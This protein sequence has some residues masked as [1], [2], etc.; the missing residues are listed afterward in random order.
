MTVRSA[1]IVGACSGIAIAI[2][3]ELA[4]R[5]FELSLLARDP[6][7]LDAVA[8][9]LRARGAT[10]ID[11]AALDLCDTDAVERVFDRLAGTGLRPHLVLLAQGIMRENDECS[12][13]PAVLRRMFDTNLA[14][15]AH[16]ALRAVALMGPSADREL[17]VISSVAGDRGRP[18]NYC[19]GATKAGLDAFLEG[20]R[21]AQGRDGPNVMNLKPGPVATAMSAHLEKGPLWAA[22]DVVARVVCNAMGKRR[23]RVYAPRWWRPVMWV[24]RQLPGSVLARLGI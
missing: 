21:L 19:Y 8:E 2:A 13:D 12:R 24:V 6:A 10:V 9:D 7:R 22:P 17:V 3:R 11:C 23:H 4:A 15:V 20:L 5:G 14:S 18:K 16:C 1:L